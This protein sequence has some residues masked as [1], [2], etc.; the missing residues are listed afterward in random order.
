[1]FVVYGI[2]VK[3]GLCV[4]S[5]GSSIDN[6][7]RFNNMDDFNCN[8]CWGQSLSMQQIVRGQNMIFFMI[9]YSIHQKYYLLNYLVR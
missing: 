2:Q 5:Q 3:I 4:E 9:V 7:G 6:S 1:M 8:L